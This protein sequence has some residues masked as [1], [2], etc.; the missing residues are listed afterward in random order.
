M[1]PGSGFVTQELDLLV[2]HGSRPFLA[3]TGAQGEGI[4]SMSP[5]VCDILQDNSENE[6]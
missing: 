6:F 5:C 1:S 2:T 4:L 3:P